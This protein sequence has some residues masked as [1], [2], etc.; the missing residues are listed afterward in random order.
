[1]T[2]MKMKVINPDDIV[3]SLEYRMTVGN[4]RKL[5]STVQSENS[6]QFDYAMN[7]F[8]NT[9]GELIEQVEGVF[10]EY[11]DEDETA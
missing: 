2:A 6:K 9:L 5:K 8:L 3:M 11:P 4:W 1:M 7:N 10:C